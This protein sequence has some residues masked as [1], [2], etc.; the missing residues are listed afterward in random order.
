MAH[1]LVK[2]SK[3]NMEEHEVFTR[4]SGSW[5]GVVMVERPDMTK[6]SYGAEPNCRVMSARTVQLNGHR[7]IYCELPYALF[8]HIFTSDDKDHV[9]CEAEFK[10][11]HLEVYGRAKTN[12]KEWVL[13]SMTAE[14]SAGLIN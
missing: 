2:R 4:G 3:V 9:F 12:L 8:K 11:G 6:L 14:Q 5:E 1:L 13:Y 10:D 7:A